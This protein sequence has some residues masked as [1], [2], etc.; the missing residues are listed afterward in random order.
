VSGK[1]KNIEAIYPLSPMQQGMLFHSLYAPQSGV[2][3][4]QLSCTIRGDFDT[5]AF[6]R[7]WSRV[8]ERHP[9]LRTLFVWERQDKPLQVVRQQVKTPWTQHDW[10]ALTDE[11]QQL[12]LATFLEADRARNFDLGK[13]PLL[14]LA[15]LRL[16]ADRWHFVWSF[17]HLLLD[18]WSLSLVLKEVFIF[19][20]AFHSGDE[21]MLDQPP[22]YRDYIA[23]LER[24]NLADAEQ[25]WR[26]SLAGFTAATPLVMGRSAGN[27]PIESYAEQTIQLSTA[28]TAALQSLA[29]QHQLTLNTVVQ[30]AWAILLQ[31]YSG[32][33]DVVFGATVSG[34]PPDLPG[35][36]QMVGL[37]INTLP[38]RIRIPAD[39]EVLPWLQAIQAEQFEQRQY[40]YTPLAQIQGWS[41]VPRG[42]P[43]F[44]SLVVFENYPVEQAVS[45]DEITTEIDTMRI[46]ERTNYPLNVTAIPGPEL[47]LRI[48]FDTRRFEAATISRM[49]GHLST[50]LNGIAAAPGS[51]LA[52]LPLLTEAEQQMLIAWNA[53]ATQPVPDLCFHEVF[54]S[55]AECTPDAPAVVFGDRQLSYAELHTRSNQLAHYLQALGVGPDVCVGL[56]LERSVELIVGLLGILKAGGAYV[57]LDPN[58][59]T[60]RLALVL[61]DGGIDLLLTQQD[62]LGHMPASGA[63]MVCLDA[64]WPEIARQPESTPASAARPEHLAYVI[65][66]SGSTGRPKGVQIQHRGLLNLALTLNETIYARHAERPLRVGLNA[67]LAF[68]ASVKQLIALLYGHALYIVPQELRLDGAALLDFIRQ[69]QLDLL[70]CVPVQLRQLLAAGLLDQRGWTPAALLPSGEAIDAELWSRLAQV[71]RPLFYNMY[72]PTECTVDV[73]ACCVQEAPERPS[74]GRPLANMQAYILDAQMQPL[75]IGAPGEL[76]VGGM[77]LARGYRHRPDL[78]AEK[79]VPNPFDASGGTRLYRS[80]DRVRYTADGRIEFLERVDFQVKLRGFRIELGDI[81]V[82]LQRHPAIREAVAIVREDAPPTGGQPDKRL[83][84]YLV[85]ATAAPPTVVELREYLQQHLPEYMIPAAFVFLAQLPLTPNGKIDRKALPAPETNRAE[86][87]SDYAAPRTPTEQTLAE[88]WSGVLRV[89]RVGINDDF[90]ALGG[91]SILCFQ[92]ISRAAR[93]GLRLS[94][95]QV[96]QHPTIARLAPLLEQSATILAE[97]E[98]VAGPVLLTPIQQRF[99]EQEQP[100]PQH[101][102][103]AVLL[104]L[105]QPA[106]PA[107]I[108][109]I[110]R[111]LAGHHDALR[112]RF[113]RDEGGWQQRNVG[114]E[115]AAVPVAAIDLSALPAA[116]QPA[117]I[118]SAA[119]ELQASLDLAHGPLLRAALFDLGPQQPQ[120]LLIAIHHLVVDGVSWRVLLEDFQTLYQQLSAGQPAQLPPKTTSFRQWAERLHSY[121]Q[122]ATLRDQLPYWLSVLR[123]PFSPLPVDLPGGE[124]TVASAETVEVALTADETKALLQ[125]LPSVYRSQINDVL[126]TAL[127]LA[128]AQW[129][130]NRAL[131]VDLEGHGREDLFED[132]DL[133]RT[134]GWFTALSPVLLDLRQASTAIDALKA[135]KEQLRRVPQHGVGYGLLRYLSADPAISESLRGAPH[136]D[137]V[138]NYLGQLDQALPSSGIVELAQESSGLSVS[139]HGRRS[140]LL[141]INGSVVGG[142]LRLHWTYSAHL[143]QRATIQRVADTCIATLRSLIT[144]ARSG[145][146]SGLTPL[147]FPKARVN[148]KDL[149]K[150]MQKLKTTR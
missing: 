51:R 18:G 108:Q 16:A 6:E 76:Y 109:Q 137:V 116:E 111:H 150:L 102:N 110:M 44:E 112:L 73:T 77:G 37:F 66:T 147:D 148:Q 14:R 118:E 144:Q 5:L 53:T 123:A 130:G 40:E 41:E 86:L 95:R 94:P 136:A 23:W 13:A 87:G 140:H 99:F 149:D 65:Y 105:R 45:Q 128:L 2:Y 17:H 97:Q 62:L 96:F 84:A 1:D 26:R 85:A 48:R 89:E 70:D 25:F 78:T 8:I 143:H 38:V 98:P 56:C 22:P 58:Y 3:F 27:E 107:L 69:H 145:D 61:N 32:E 33:R 141:A 142:Q 79:F 134:V 124:N 11:E 47:S 91:D 52:A 55:Q 72:G 122:T 120:R 28:T 59:P 43:L 19:Y 9:A 4:V 132:V 67:P 146:V 103:Q 100:E 29:R 133:S 114:L 119:T 60:E 126:L 36:E 113:S 7:A 92:V 88:I 121:A 83:V 74:I 35:V 71:A 82:T 42:Q 129:S 57:P 15:L 12:Q 101:Y 127:G 39:G 106:D 131:L 117:A 54:A 104:S 135:I 10:R 138:F 64:D 30:G 68:D 50:L 139:S 21:P 75:P 46:A 24:Q 63:H 90:F 34:R 93:A 80:G 125:E 81:E 20:E 31:R 115:A 49:L